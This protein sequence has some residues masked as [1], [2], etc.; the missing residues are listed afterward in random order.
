MK[1]GGGERGGGPGEEQVQG[2]R[3]I[4][5]AFTVPRTGAPKTEDKMQQKQFFQDKIA[6]KRSQIQEAH[7]L[8]KLNLELLCDP[9]ILLLVIYPKELKQVF[10]KL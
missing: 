4:Q 1:H 8:I 10:F 7:I 6:M 9:A 2:M 5:A 3:G